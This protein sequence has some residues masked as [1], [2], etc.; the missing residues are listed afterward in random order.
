MYP[1][2]TRA[3][4]SCQA[5]RTSLISVSSSKEYTDS[6]HPQPRTKA[7]S[8]EGTGTPWEVTHQGRI[9]NRADSRDLRKE[10]P[11]YQR[12]VIGL[13]AVIGVVVLAATLHAQ[14]FSADV[15]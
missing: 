1:K 13:T 11:M 15:I 14:E 3:P 2:L 4:P 10:N 6:T 7:I 8:P 12:L 9:L 5:A